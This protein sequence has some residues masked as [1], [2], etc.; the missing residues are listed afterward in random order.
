M[1]S[2]AAS[3]SAIPEEGETEA[4]MEEEEDGLG[5]EGFLGE[6]ERSD[7]DSGRGEEGGARVEGSSPIGGGGVSGVLES[8][9]ETKS[10]WVSFFFFASSTVCST[11]G[12]GGSR[13]S[14]MVSS[15]SGVDGA[16]VAR[17]EEEAPLFS[18]SC[19][20]SGDAVDTGG[21]G[22]RVAATGALASVVPV[23]SAIV[24]NDEGDEEGEDATECRIS[25]AASEGPT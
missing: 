3:F 18:S 10:V 6:E 25:T 4:S 2:P 7:S 14:I 20:A 22:D 23:T 21:E 5:T 15:P 12:R 8:S 9:D 19:G 1:G 17:K 24:T 16:S 13:R 11:A